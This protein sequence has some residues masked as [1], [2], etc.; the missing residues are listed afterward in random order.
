MKPADQNPNRS[1]DSSAS[2]TPVGGNHQR[3]GRPAARETQGSGGHPT[4]PECIEFD[5]REGVAPRHLKVD[6]VA[7]SQFD[8]LPNGPL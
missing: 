7:L 2:H 6:A 1:T 4:Q 3:A 5:G 8:A